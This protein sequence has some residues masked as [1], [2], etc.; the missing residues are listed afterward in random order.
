MFE[1]VKLFPR[2]PLAV[3]IASWMFFFVLQIVVLTLAAYGRYVPPPEPHLLDH[4]WFVYTELPRALPMAAVYAACMV[5]VAQVVGRFVANN[6]PDNL[7]IGHWR[8]LLRE[9]PTRAIKWMGLRWYFCSP[10]WDSSLAHGYL[11]RFGLT[12]S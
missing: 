11:S 2:R 4:M 12:S 6:N 7:T 9:N 8:E 1:L 5:F 3:T 10:W